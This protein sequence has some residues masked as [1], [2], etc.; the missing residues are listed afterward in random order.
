MLKRDGNM[1]PKFDLN[2]IEKTQVIP[3]KSSTMVRKYW[4]PPIATIDKGSQI[5]TCTNSKDGKVHFLVQGKGKP[6]VLG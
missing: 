4:Y 3:V 6:F 1:V 5:S 2:F